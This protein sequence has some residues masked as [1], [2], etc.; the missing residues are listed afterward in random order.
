MNIYSLQETALT[1]TFLLKPETLIPL[2]PK[3]EGDPFGQS[4]GEDFY[5]SGMVPSA[6]C[7]FQGIRGLVNHSY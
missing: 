5:S 6:H 3:E 1:L 4:L 7:V 2:I